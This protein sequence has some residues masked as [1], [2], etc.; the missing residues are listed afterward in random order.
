MRWKAHRRDLASGR[1]YNHRLQ[2]D[3]IKLGEEAFDFSL[4]ESTKAE[5]LGEKEAEWHD[6]FSAQ[7]AGVYNSRPIGTRHQRPAWDRKTTASHAP[8]E[9]DK[10]LS[11][12]QHRRQRLWTI[13][14]LASQAGVATQTIV[15]IEHGTTAPQLGTMKKIAAALDVD[16]K[17]ITEFAAAI[18]G[19]KASADAT[20]KDGSS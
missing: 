6:H 15:G 18:Q 2:E 1:H 9:G 12:R 13:R 8:G 11:V 3:W 4:I 10:R 14:E 5:V 19:A 7:S 16:P 17:E 20:S